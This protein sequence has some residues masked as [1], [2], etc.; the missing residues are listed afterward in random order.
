MPTLHLLNQEGPE[1]PQ[2]SYV[3][4]GIMESGWWRVSEARAR[5]MIDYPIHFHR[6]MAEA[7]FL[8]GIVTGFRL[9]AYTTPKGNTSPRTIFLF[10]PVPDGHLVTDTTG[11]TLAGVKFVS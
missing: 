5:S 2:P 4:P 7:S 3:S 11:W 6:R 1:F 9:E 8:S 10:T